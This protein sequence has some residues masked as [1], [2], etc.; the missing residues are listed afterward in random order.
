MTKAVLYDLLG[1]YQGFIAYVLYKMSNTVDLTSYG[2]RCQRPVVWINPMCRDCVQAPVQ[3]WHGS[4]PVRAPFSSQETISTRA[5]TEM[6]AELLVNLSWSF[7]PELPVREKGEAQLP[8]LHV[9]NV[10][11]FPL[12]RR[13]LSGKS[14]V[15][16]G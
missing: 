6:L 2:G 8:S 4:F 7:G 9:G 1:C 13:V 12:M 16:F 5:L 11:C 10:M 3:S 14:H 15:T